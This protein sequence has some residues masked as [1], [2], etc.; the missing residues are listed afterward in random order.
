MDISWAKLIPRL[1]KDGSLKQP[2]R[3][4]SCLDE[5]RIAARQAIHPQLE[6]MLTKGM[7]VDHVYPKTFEKLLYDWV[8]HVGVRV[9]HIGVCSNNGTMVRRWFSDPCLQKSWELYHE[10]N[11]VLKV[12]TP[13]EHAIQPVLRVDWSELL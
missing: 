11:A 13:Q 3:E 9:S 6:H 10:R 2:P 4:Q 8:L 7:H 5:L 12:L 1:Q